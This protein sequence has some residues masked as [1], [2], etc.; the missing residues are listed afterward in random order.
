MVREVLSRRFR[1][2]TCAVFLVVALIAVACSQYERMLSFDAQITAFYSVYI[3][4]CGVLGYCFAGW[5]TVSDTSWFETVSVPIAIAL[6]S[7]TGASLFGLTMDAIAGRAPDPYTAFLGAM[8][9][10]VKLLVTT[11]LLTMVIGIC[12]SIALGFRARTTA[13]AEPNKTM[14]PT[15]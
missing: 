14:E 9:L 3:S 6:L 13:G 7:S 11:G 5:Y 4:A 15:R 2:E 10:A 12:A 8:F 1:M